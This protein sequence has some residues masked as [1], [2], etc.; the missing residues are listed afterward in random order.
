MDDLQ[1]FLQRV[2]TK[3][4]ALQEHFPVFCDDRQKLNDLFGVDALLFPTLRQNTLK[5]RNRKMPKPR[6]LLTTQSSA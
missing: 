3:D 4:G 1:A 2:T 6:T 5:R